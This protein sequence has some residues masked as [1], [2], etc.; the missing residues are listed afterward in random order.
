M[1]PM[2]AA[3]TFADGLAQCGLLASDRLDHGGLLRLDWV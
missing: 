2:I 1:G 3:K